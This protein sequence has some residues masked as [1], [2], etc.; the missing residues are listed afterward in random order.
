CRTGTEPP[1]YT[2]FSELDAFQARVLKLGDMDGD[3]RKDLITHGNQSAA[4]MAEPHIVFFDEQ[5]EP[6][7]VRDI[8]VAMNSLALLPVAATTNSATERVQ[9]AGATELGIATLEANTKQQITAVPNPFH[10]MPFGWDYRMVRIRGVVNSPL[11]E[12]VVI[13]DTDGDVSEA[14]QHLPIANIGR[15]LQ[16]VAGPLI[17]GNVIDDKTSPCD[18]VII[19]YLDDPEIYRLDACD[20]EGRLLPHSGKMQAIASLPKG[21]VVRGAKLAFIDDDEHLDL[22]VANDASTSASSV[23][24]A[25]G[26]GDGT[27]SADPEYPDLT[28]GTLWPVIPQATSAVTNNCTNPFELGQ[29]FPLAVADLNADKLADWVLPKGVAIVQRLRFESEQPAIHVVACLTN[30]P[31]N[32][33]WSVAEIADPNRDER[34]DVVAGSALAPDLDFLAGTGRDNLNPVSLRTS[35]PV[36]Q[37][38]TGDFDTDQT[39][40]VAVVE[41]LA[42]DAVNKGA[43]THSLAVAYGDPMH[44][45]APPIEVA[46]FT[47]LAVDQLVSA[48]Y[49]TDDASEE[50]GLLTRSPSNSAQQLMIFIGNQ[51][52]LPI[53]PLGLWNFTDTPDRQSVIGW[54]VALTVGRFNAVDRWSAIALALDDAQG[55]ICPN[56][57]SL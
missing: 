34:P 44:V 25:F 28:M 12:R 27:F 47:S 24:V 15:P 5:G 42:P 56:R 20:V 4:W 17:A 35:G 33:S 41:A 50:I 7:T 8:H 14:E 11:R 46:R 3:G 29:D 57:L 55:R 22:L 37:L 52:R 31:S 10:T 40:D 21:S 13:Y 49:E 53:A 18:E 39:T 38:I 19:T 36:Q 54:P 16:E 26:N 6:K 32:G 51:G 48:N 23:F 30:H 45:L 43:P 1:A 9:L 2:V